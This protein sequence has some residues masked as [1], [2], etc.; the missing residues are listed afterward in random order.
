MPRTRSLAWSELKIGLVSVFALVIAA[1][2]IFM[3]SG[4][5][6][7]FWQRYSIKT[8]FANIAGL[9]EGA[10]VRVAGVEVGSV[11]KLDFVGDKV[12]VTMEVSKEQQPRITDRRPRRSDRCR[13]WAKRPWTS[14]PT[15][16]ARRFPNGDTCRAGAAPGSLATA[17]EQA[18]KGLEQTTALLSGHPRREGHARQAGDRRHALSR[19]E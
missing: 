9:K 2:L 18:T 8:V 10:P 1:V 19:A 4:S 11:T 17:A 16:R 13:C 7:F 15:A 14:R 12:E 3:V 6:G 5:G